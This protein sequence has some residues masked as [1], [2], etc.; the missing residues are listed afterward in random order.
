MILAPNPVSLQYRENRHKQACMLLSRVLCHTSGLGS[1]STLSDGRAVLKI[2]QER[3]GKK[4][5][6]GKDGEP[7]GPSHLGLLP[8]Q[9]ERRSTTR[10]QSA[11]P[12]DW[13]L[14]HEIAHC[15]PSNAKDDGGVLLFQGYLTGWGFLGE[16]R[17]SMNNS[18]LSVYRYRL[19]PGED[20]T[21]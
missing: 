16:G 10:P 18:C 1:L 4:E 5:E 3:M 14:S 6:G 7:I 11:G 8:M 17:I 15:S 21:Q 12:E 2:R 19:W 9:P 20:C 13:R